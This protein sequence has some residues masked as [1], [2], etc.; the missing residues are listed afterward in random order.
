MVVSNTD[1]GQR[2]QALA[3]SISELLTRTR[4]TNTAIEEQATQLTNLQAQVRSFEERVFT[5]PE[6]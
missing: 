1:Q 4:A 3:D 6:Q 5:L 2:M